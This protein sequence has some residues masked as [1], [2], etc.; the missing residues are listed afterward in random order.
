V[1]VCCVEGPILAEPVGVARACRSREAGVLLVVDAVWRFGRR[2]G[3]CRAG[4]RWVTGA[5]IVSSAILY[6]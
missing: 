4:A 1:F 3:R 5:M 2:P 6:R